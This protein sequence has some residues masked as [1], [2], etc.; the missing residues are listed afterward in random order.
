MLKLRS[1]NRLT[2]RVGADF[3]CNRQVAKVCGNKVAAVPAVWNQQ[4]RSFFSN[5]RSN[6]KG[7]ESEGLGDEKKTIEH[8]RGL[9]PG[10][11]IQ[12]IERG[13]KNGSFPA[14]E[15]IVK[16]YLKSASS[17]KKLDSLDITGLLS[18]IQQGGRTP[19]AL[20]GMEGAERMT[21]EAMYA[22]MQPMSRTTAGASPKDPIY[23]KSK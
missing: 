22:A 12:K 3:P 15:G 6:S 2:R 10:E 11:A 18:L 14:S 9:K 5:L 17:L 8:L 7:S 16:E 23:V 21:P 13:W 20:A 19:G 4:H 1:A